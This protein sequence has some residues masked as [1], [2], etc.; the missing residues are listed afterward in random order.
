MLQPHSCGNTRRFLQHLLPTGLYFDKLASTGSAQAA[1]VKVR[2][3]GLLIPCH[4][5]PIDG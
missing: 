5:M 3:Y 4:K 2:Y 1:Q